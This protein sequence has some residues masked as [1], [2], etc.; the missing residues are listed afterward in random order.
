MVQSKY[1]RAEQVGDIKHPV[2]P[3]EKDI[4]NIRFKGEGR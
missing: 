1:K 4:I 2:S 3:K